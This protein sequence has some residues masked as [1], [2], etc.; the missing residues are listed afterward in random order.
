MGACVPH[1][2]N[3][4]SDKF[5]NK[6]FIVYI[7]VSNNKIFDR[8]NKLLMIILFILFRIRNHMEVQQHHATLQNKNKAA[9]DHPQ[10]DQQN[11][12]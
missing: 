8:F 9:H 5:L 11:D 3:K 4:L 6:M 2:Y 7:F 12:L 10:V 1:C